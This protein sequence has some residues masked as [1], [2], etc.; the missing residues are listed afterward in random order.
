MGRIVRSLNRTLRF[1]VALPSVIYVTVLLVLPL[2]I[3]FA[4]GL[5]LGSW[6][7]PYIRRVLFFTYSQAALSAFL[8]VL[9][10]F[11]VAFFCADNPFPGRKALLRLSLLPFALPTLLV[12]LSIASTWGL[13]RLIGWPGFL[14]VHVF[15]NAPIA[16]RAVLETLLRIERTEECV[17]LSLGA[18]RTRCF[19]EFTLPK[20]LPSLRTAFMLSFLY[21]AASFLPILVFGG[22]PQYTSIEVAIFQAVK[23]NL[24]MGRASFLGA[25]QIAISGVLALLVFRETPLS[26]KNDAP[27]LPLYRFRTF[28]ARWLGFGLV[29]LVLGA[30]YGLPLLRLLIEG[31]LAMFVSGIPIGV[32]ALITTL[33]IAI[34]A[35]TV[36]A[37]LGLGL[38]YARS[39]SHTRWV[40]HATQLLALLPLFLSGVLISFSWL[41]VAPDLVY[42]L[43]GNLLPILLIHGTLALPL[44]FRLLS[45][46][47]QEMDPRWEQCGRGLGASEGQIFR[48]I[49]VPFL[50]RTLFLCFLCGFS[51]S[52]GEVGAPLLFASDNLETLS[53]L[54]FRSLSQ[55]R[56][57]DAKSL[58]FILFALVT[59]GFTLSELKREGK[60]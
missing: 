12:V 20:L 49:E 18:T 44:S 14:L 53:L 4:H 10:G 37:A 33:V 27:V 39:K 52:I 11:S 38:V 2:G 8:S 9:L 31:G 3:F 19:R 34:G 36:S 32:Q 47:W 23:M 15:F 45:D 57:Q 13:A 54:L 43:R 59:L 17:A 24:D 50:H 29:G 40:A 60:R 58:G 46:R 56:F 16:F 42:R 41:V 1:W 22:S 25:C 21:C 55:Y 51:L 7:E 28:G 6:E 5:H 26:R 48:L 30:I 35:G